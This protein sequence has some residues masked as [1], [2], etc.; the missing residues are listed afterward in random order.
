MIWGSAVTV[1]CFGVMGVASAA[2]W[3]L[4]YVV[5]LFF[6]QLALNVVYSAQCGLPA[7]LQGIGP[8]DE[9]PVGSSANGLVSGAVALHSFVGSLVAMGVVIGTR[10]WPVQY[11]YPLFMI[12]VL[13]CAAV[14]C[15]S[16]RE[17]P[18]HMQPAKAS[19]SLAELGRSYII[20]PD[21]DSDF[22]WVCVGR[23]CYY[24]STCPVVFIKYYIRD[25]LHVSS[26]ETARF[27]LGVLVISA[28]LVG[29]V[30]SI[31]FSRL[32]NKAGRKMVIYMACATMTGTYLLYIIAPKVGPNGSW[33]LVLVAGLC[34]GVGSGAYLSV[35]YALALDCLPHGKTTAE[36]FGLWGVAGFIGATAGPMVGGSL[37]WTTQQD[38]DASSGSDNITAYGYLGYALVM[39]ML[40][41]AMNGFVVFFTKKIQ[42]AK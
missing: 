1:T 13:I 17:S 18:T 39:A 2:L 22:L 36:A 31:P 5:F 30:F 10:S 25:M 34:Y 11:E 38:G 6:G 9:P 21:R 24:V 35:D 37:L 41:C 28:Q 23:M 42:K 4:V 14:V 20:D 12:A 27:N 7:D 19:L 15:V 16:A 8:D 26:E 33:P 3:P 32:S 40:G 29:A